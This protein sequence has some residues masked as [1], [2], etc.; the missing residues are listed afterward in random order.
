MLL[1]ERIFEVVGKSVLKEKAL[2][3]EEILEIELVV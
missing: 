2:E 3:M 1:L